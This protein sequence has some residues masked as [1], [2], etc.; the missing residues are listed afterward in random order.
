MTTKLQRYKGR[1]ASRMAEGGHPYVVEMNA[2]PHGE[3][4]LYADVAPLEVENVRLLNERE[5]LRGLKLKKGG[6]HAY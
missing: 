2:L 4:V 5:R 1:I 3:Y 6:H